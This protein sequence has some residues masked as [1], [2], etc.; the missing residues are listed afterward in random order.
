MKIS[1]NAK[2]NSIFA[3]G[4]IFLALSMV[5]SKGR[6]DLIEQLYSLKPEPEKKTA[7]PR[8]KKK[9]TTSK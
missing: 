4:G 2:I 6:S 5:Y 9:A 7:M 3:I 8:A 1:F